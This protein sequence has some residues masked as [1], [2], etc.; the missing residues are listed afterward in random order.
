MRPQPNT[1]SH[2]ACP[3]ARENLE[4]QQPLPTL[5]RALS[6]LL[7]T[8][9]FMNLLPKEADLS[10]GPAPSEAWCKGDSTWE[11]DCNLLVDSGLGLASAP[12]GQKVL[13]SM[14]LVAFTNPMA[15]L[16]S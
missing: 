10:L 5:F 13:S 8:H 15:Q 1:P 12:S 4:L 14:S 9:L 3:S 2:E 11:Q 7:P 16:G 6:L